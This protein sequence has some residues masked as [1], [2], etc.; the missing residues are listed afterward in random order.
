M[1]ASAVDTLGE[2]TSKAAT[3]LEA[4]AVPIRRF[5]SIMNKQLQCD[6]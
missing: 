5:A 3:Q 2:A 6:S 4:S 1:S